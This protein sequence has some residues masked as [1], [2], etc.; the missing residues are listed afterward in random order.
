MIVN[1]PPAI[2]IVTIADRGN[3]TS[4]RVHLQVTRDCDLSNYLLLATIQAGPGKVYAGLRPAYWFNA[5]QVKEGD[6]IIVYTREGQVSKEVRP[7]QHINHFL[8]WGV[9]NAMFGPGAMVVIGELNAWQ[10]GP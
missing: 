5:E 9:K 1:S 6:H 8:F 10:A 7:D 3:L 4:E 2:K